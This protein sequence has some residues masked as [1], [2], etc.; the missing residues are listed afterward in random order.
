MTH[1]RAVL[2]LSTAV[3]AGLVPGATAAPPPGDRAREPSSP[4]RDAAAPVVSITEGRLTLKVVKRPLAVVLDALTQESGIPIVV[5][6]AAGDDLVSVE[7][8]DIPWD[9]GLRRLLSGHDAFYLY[10]GED[11]TAAS[12]RAVW[13][14]PRGGGKDLQPT[15]P[16]T[17]ASTK[18]LEGKLADPDRSVR[19]R[20][21]EGLIDR[22]HERALEIV[23]R[24]LRE[25][26]DA[27]VRSRVLYA[28]LNKGLE[29]P[30]ELLASLASGDGSD[31]VRFLALNAL[32]SDPNAGA[33]ATTA[34]SDPS[35]QVR[36]RARE[37][38]A[39]L[40]DGAPPED[41]PEEEPAPDELPREP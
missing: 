24:G 4:R 9:E 5:A 18:E 31:Q 40:G 10:G 28:A 11:R 29:L 3:L 12:L 37:I 32:E 8:H 21:Y 2:V 19:A 14:Y 26:K 34:L 41:G 7:V 17:W 1:S 27:E 35:P 15:P 13:V 36:I 38:L 23:V 30:T 33:I 22:Q 25:D 6:G 39:A 16:E 20:A